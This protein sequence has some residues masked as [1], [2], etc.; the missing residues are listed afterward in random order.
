[1]RGG[2]A[3]PVVTRTHALFLLLLLALS[4]CSLFRSPPPVQTEAP[5]AASEP[6]QPASEPEAASAP[7]AASEPE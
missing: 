3:R 4:G 6:E 2:F 5:V 7:E 1:M